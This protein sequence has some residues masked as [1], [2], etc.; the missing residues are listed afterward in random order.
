M[1]LVLAG[2]AIAMALA[3]SA[4]TVGSGQVAVHR[5]RIAIDEGFG[6]NLAQAGLDK[7]GTFFVWPLSTTDDPHSPGQFVATDKGKVT[8]LVRDGNSSVRNGM[9]VHESAAREELNGRRGTLR[10]S[11][12]FD[13]YDIPVNGSR[14]L[15]GTWRIAGGTGAYSGL[16][17]GGRYVGVVKP[18]GGRVARLEGWVTR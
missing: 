18:A 13:V 5:Q 11:V 9:A 12:R 14:A 1:R 10:L 16:R 2:V 8:S 17:G 4:A 3:G 6:A 15:L 7:P